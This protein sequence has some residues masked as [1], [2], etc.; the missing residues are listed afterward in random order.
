M[1]FVWMIYFYHRTFQPYYAH[2][3]CMYCAAFGEINDDEDDD[4]TAELSISAS[5]RMMTT[6]MVM[7]LSWWTALDYSQWHGITRQRG[8]SCAHRHIGLVHY[9]TGFSVSAVRV[10]S[11]RNTKIISTQAWTFLTKIARWLMY[12]VQYAVDVTVQCDRVYYTEPVLALW[13][14]V[15]PA[16][17]QHLFTV[18]H[19]I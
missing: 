3:I 7:M 4:Y 5:A 14:S 2:F 8:Q 9:Y 1:Y 12:I 16:F 10:Q 13:H 19:F 17:Y 18:L 6:M 15:I 11:E